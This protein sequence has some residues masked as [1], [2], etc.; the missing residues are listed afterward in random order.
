MALSRLARIYGP[1]DRSRHPHGITPVQE[2]HYLQDMLTNVAHLE[3]LGLSV[4]LVMEIAR[5]RVLVEL[6]HE[7]DG[8]IIS[9]PL[10]TH[11]YMQI[12][13][14]NVREEIEVIAA[15]ILLVADSYRS[16]K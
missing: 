6:H 7:R 15:K 10:D 8:V 11:Y 9:E 3:P 16:R 4:H 12:N 13:N 14:G 5:N 2:R 1:Q